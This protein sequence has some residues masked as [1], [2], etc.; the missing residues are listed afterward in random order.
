MVPFVPS[1]RLFI[2]ISVHF[3]YRSCMCVR[4]TLLL[5][6]FTAKGKPKIARYMAVFSIVFDECITISLSRTDRESVDV[7]NV[8]RVSHET[9]QIGNSLIWLLLCQHSQRERTRS[10]LSNTHTYTYTHAYA[11]CRAR[12]PTKLSGPIHITTTLCATWSI[13]VAV[14]T[15]SQAHASHVLLVVDS[16]TLKSLRKQWH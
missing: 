8:L 15:A 6:L 5:L 12:T 10:A 13:G 1:F 16:C 7:S 11:D 3:D 4:L 9:C 2:L 14:A